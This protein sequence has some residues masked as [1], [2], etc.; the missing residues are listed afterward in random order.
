M[1]TINVIFIVG[2]PLLL[3]QAAAAVLYAER[4]GVDHGIRDWVS[5]LL[6]PVL[7]FWFIHAEARDRAHP[8]PL[9]PAP[10][11]P[12]LCPACQLPV[13]AGQPRCS[14]CGRA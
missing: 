14:G 5:A 9:A 4:K 6:L 13:I 1:D 12:E 10:S 11:G 8:G 2:I 7:V 3:V